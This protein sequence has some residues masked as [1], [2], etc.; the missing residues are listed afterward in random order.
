M[1]DAGSGKVCR[2]RLN[3]FLVGQRR[4]GKLRCFCAF[5]IGCPIPYLHGIVL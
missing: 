4:A 3:L 2:P 5:V 1:Q